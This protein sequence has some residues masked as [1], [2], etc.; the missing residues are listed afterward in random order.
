MAVVKNLMTR[1]GFDASGMKKGVRQGMQELNTFKS[2]VSKT[3]KG[4]TAALATIGIGAAIRSATKEAMGFEASMGQIQRTMG[5]SAQAFTKWASSGAAAFNLSKAEAVKYGAV[6]SNLISGFA[7]DTATATKYTTDLLKA[8]GVIASATGREMTD[9]MDR[10]RS[11]MLGNT[12]AI[13]DLGINVNIAMIESTDAFKKFA[14]GK[15]WAKLSFQ[16][17][18]QIRLFAILEQ[19][20][21]KYGTALADNTTTAQGRFLLQLKNARLALGQAFLPIYNVVLPA[22]TRLATALANAMNVV[23]QFS[24]ALFGKPKEQANATAAQASA[25]GDLGDAY[26]KAGKAAQKSVAGFDQLNL[27]G[28]TAAA[29]ADGGAIG[30]PGMTDTPAAD[31]GLDT[32]S[33]SAKV[34]KMAADV[35]AA[36][37]DMSNFIGTHK[38]LILASLAAL[39]TGF[40][41]FWLIA[42]GG[43]ATAAIKTAF[44]G[45]ASAIGAVSLPAL[46]I[47]A[48]IAALVG[49]FVYFYRTN[50]TFRDTVHTILQKIGDTAVWLW[51][52]VLVPLGKFLADVFV[53]AWNGVSTAAG[54]LWKNVLIPLGSYLMWFWHNVTVPISEALGG[55]LASA[56]KVLSDIAKSFWQKVMIPLGDFFS[57]VFGPAV[58]AQSAIFQF[59]GDKVLKPFG[60]Y[61]GTVLKP[62]FKGLTDVI[63]YLSDKVLEP[64]VKFVGGALKS[65]FNTV[66]EGIGETING[67][68]TTIIGLMTFITGVFTGDWEKAWDGIGDT[69]KGVF[70]SLYGYVKIPLN[71][72]ITA[73]NALISGLNKLSIDVPSWVEKIPG[74]PDGISSFGFNIPKIPKLAKGGLAFGPTLAMVGDNKGAASNPEVIAPLS[75]LEDMMSGDD[76][77]EVVSVLKAILQAVKSSGN[78][79][80]ASFSKMDL[81]RAAV[82][83]INDLTRRSGRNP[84]VT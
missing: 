73:I 31:V 40:A 1:A 59:L 54:W 38:D 68:K 52:S 28:D 11:G 66:F 18:Q 43:T 23:A 20:T 21:K 7:K 75:K 58:D 65:T 80:T 4:I 19:S 25:V 63:V 46:L 72:I 33:V 24:Q 77:R 50:E 61:I 76:N 10:I 42:K 69:F 82:T 44:A 48:A 5:G 15:S 2:G 17:Q 41:T 81:G 55:V 22:L 62:I 32:E 37:K 67:F 34:K 12:E 6:Y 49:A 45:I 57:D 56:F 16:T 13:E 35:K 53:K 29:G 30:I 9:V 60:T 39:G 47:G 26:T 3:M 83:G 8:S 51:Q 36:F 71:L 14:N 78:S 84:L 79:D 64:L 27:I 70:D 74:V